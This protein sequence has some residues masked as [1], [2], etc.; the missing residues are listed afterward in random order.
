MDVLEDGV[1]VA[2]PGGPTD[3]LG[4]HLTDP[5]TLVVVPRY[6]LLPITV[7]NVVLTR[8]ISLLRFDPMVTLQD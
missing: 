6:E 4:A 7:C 2:V 3:V 5:F 8:L 1:P